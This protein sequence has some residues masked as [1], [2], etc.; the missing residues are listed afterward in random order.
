MTN[1][2]LKIRDQ[3]QDGY[4]IER[5]S[6]EYIMSKVFTLSNDKVDSS[7]I[8][9]YLNGVLKILNT[10]YTYD[11]TNCSITY[12]GTIVAG[13]TVLITYNA[14]QK[15]SDTELQRFIRSA[16]SY[17]VVEKYKCFIIKPP[18]TI[19]PSPTEDEEF[20]IAIIASILIKNDMVSYRTPELTINFERGDNKE[21]K[22]KK[23]VR[24]FKKS[25]GVVDFV[26]LKADNEIEDEDE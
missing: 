12:I 7:T 3:I 5:D 1:I 2:I 6:F 10:D 8:N 17:L 13:S 14:Y 22:I 18:D 4:V 24:N 21:K 16:I 19:F 9:V 11:S 23:L 20:L 25:I 26:D 15:Y